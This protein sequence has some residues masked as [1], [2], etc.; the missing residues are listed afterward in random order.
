[1]MESPLTRVA[2]RDMP[3]GRLGAVLA[4][5]VARWGEK[6]DQLRHDSAASLEVR[7]I[8]T[9]TG[10]G[11]RHVSY[12]G[13]YVVRTCPCHEGEEITQPFDTP[14]RAERALAVLDA[15]ARRYARR[16]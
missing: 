8:Q 15:D 2:A 12:D 16:S 13:W 11:R 4:A 9:R 7:F 6:M 14:E 3:P 10:A 5:V 1:M